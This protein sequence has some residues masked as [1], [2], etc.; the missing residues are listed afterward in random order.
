MKFESIE[1]KEQFRWPTGPRSQSIISTKEGVGPDVA[2]LADSEHGVI[3]SAG[4]RGT[5]LVPWSN[6][7]IASVLTP[8]PVPQLV[9]AESIKKTIPN[10][11][12]R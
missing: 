11:R 9:K 7:R 2:E 8:K 4:D 5:V 6:I 3:V 10:K 12:K 1:V